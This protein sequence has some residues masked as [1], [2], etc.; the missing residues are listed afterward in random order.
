[1]SIPARAA[2]RSS[3]AAL[4][5]VAGCALIT[6]FSCVS[7]QKSTV[8]Q[9]P[10]VAATATPVATA[11]VVGFASVGSSTT[12]GAAGRTVTATTLAELTTYATSAEPLVI[13][14]GGTISGG[15]E[16]A[17]IRVKSN[18]TLLGVGA[19][20]FLEG[21]GLNLVDAQNVIVQNLKFTMSTVTKTYIN[22]E[23]R[24]QVATND[25]DCVTIQGNSQNIWVD[26][27]EFFNLDPATQPNQDLYDGL[28]DAKDNSANITISWSYF[29][30]HHK[31]HLVGS[32]DKEAQNHDRRIT[33]HHNYYRN[34]KERVPS[35]RFGTGHVFNN[36][37]QHVRGSGVNAR[38]GACLRVE[39][40]YFEDVRD[41]VVTKNSPASGFWDVLDNVY[42]N[43]SGSQPTTAS[44]P[45]PLQLPYDYKSA[46]T[47]AADVKTVVMQGAGVGK[48]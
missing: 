41:P 34:I 20:G 12:G 10:S 2:A 26:H 40:N 9:M 36:Y 23:K 31:C 16:G 25:G 46:L 30:D 42:Q 21:V 37:Y 3:T 27:C 35:F 4:S 33:F 22:S 29:H 39:Q 7:E 44:C 8:P 48:L 43:C 47:P 13:R 19:T 5:L 6:S 17:S 24:A 32:S 15:S 14:I 28:V 11:G 38:M 45:T 18:K 1:M